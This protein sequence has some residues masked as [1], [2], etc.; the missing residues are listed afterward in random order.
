MK[1]FNFSRTT[2]KL[3][4]DGDEYEVKVPTVGEGD[5]FDEQIKKASEGKI[6]KS[7]TQVTEE[8]FE[9]IGLPKEAYR[10]LEGWQ[11]KEI[12]LYFQ[13]PQKKS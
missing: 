8:Y 6:K 9:K 2:I 3:K 4:V 1:E 5:W 11:V 10:K 13:D 7:I 12:L